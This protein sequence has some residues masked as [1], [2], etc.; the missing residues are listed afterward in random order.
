MT[1]HTRTYTFAHLPF[2]SCQLIYLRKAV[3]FQT[4]QREDL[5]HRGDALTLIKGAFYLR[6]TLIN[7]HPESVA[8]ENIDFSFEFEKV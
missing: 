3:I 4:L 2:T 6:C 5:Q 1:R 7:W 8:R